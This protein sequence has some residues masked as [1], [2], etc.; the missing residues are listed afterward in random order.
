MVI[1]F[2]I[3]AIV[4]CCFCLVKNIYLIYIGRIIYGFC[5]GVFT[6]ATPK[7]IDDTIPAHVIDK[8]YG[9][10]TNLAINLY[11][12][13]SMGLGLGMPDNDDEASLKTTQFWRVIYGLPIVFNVLA[14]I[15]NIFV[16]T[17]DSLRFH[18]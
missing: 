17:E 4:S 7:I 5:T 6:C 2:N 15:L 11:V 8:G 3:I 12:M 13:I 10:S 9:I 16:H 18:I 14:I 1:L